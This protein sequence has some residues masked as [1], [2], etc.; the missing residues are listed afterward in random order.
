M[1][2]TEKQRHTELLSNFQDNIKKSWQIIK[3]IANRNK[4][5][6]LQAKS[7]LNN[8]SFTADGHIISNKLNDFS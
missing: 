5:N 1:E 7:K 8:G 3:G 4:A 2:V 6:Q